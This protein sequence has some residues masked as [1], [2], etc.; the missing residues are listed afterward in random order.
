MNA[1]INQLKADKLN[2]E[3]LVGIGVDGANVMVGEHHSFSSLLS[4]KIPHLV[5]VK[6]TFGC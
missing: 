1:F 6:S 5:T 3:H 4:E 2:I